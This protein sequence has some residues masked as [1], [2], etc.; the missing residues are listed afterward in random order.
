MES[1]G[2]SMQ[3]SR[4]RGDCMWHLKLR[5]CKEPAGLSF[6]Q[7]EGH[8]ALRKGWETLRPDAQVE[9]AAWDV[10]HR[11]CTVLLEAAVRAPPSCETRWPR[12]GTGSSPAT[13]S[14]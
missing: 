6:V 10:H 7:R 11:G 3:L 4:R 14:T 5:Q 2:V 8:K 1:S 9:E 12:P 13:R